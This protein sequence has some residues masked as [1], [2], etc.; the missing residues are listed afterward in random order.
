MLKSWVTLMV[1]LIFSRALLVLG[2]A[3]VD[4]RFLLS[5][6]CTLNALLVVIYIRRYRAMAIK[7]HLETTKR[8]LRLERACRGGHIPA[9]GTLPY[10]IV[11]YRWPNG[12]ISHYIVEWLTAHV[13]V[14]WLT[15]VYLPHVV[16]R[17]QLTYAVRTLG[18]L[19]A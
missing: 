9:R 10:R 5:H 6:G 3:F 11:V 19:T 8:L 16:S 7:A 12:K 15:P 1:T 13:Q 18:T 14:N 17:T 4:L 2:C